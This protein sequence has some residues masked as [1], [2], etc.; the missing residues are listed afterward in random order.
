MPTTTTTTI[1]QEK[2][3]TTDGRVVRVTDWSVLTRTYEQWH[4]MSEADFGRLSF[5]GSGRR[6]VE[7]YC[8]ESGY[9]SFSDG[10]NTAIIDRIRNGYDLERLEGVESPNTLHAEQRKRRMTDDADGEYDH[11]AFLNGDAEYYVV[12]DR[13]APKRGLHVEIS[14]C[15]SGSVSGR[16]CSE[17]GVWTAQ[18]LRALKAARHDLSI[19]AT[20][21]TDHAYDGERSSDTHVTLKRYGQTMLAADWAVLFSPGGYRSLM[22]TCKALAAHTD[23]AALSSGLG[24]PQVARDWGLDW[25]RETR[26]LKI[27]NPRNA[28]SFPAQEMTRKL[29]EILPRL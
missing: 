19:V 12:K 3:T 16:V 26:T 10:D 6:V 1:P 20:N 8:R 22:F 2:Y 18:A 21:R 27:N 9:S 11:T 28:S 4:D 13:P 24:S 23:G 25:N 5:A 7:S 15:F 17:Y 14:L 29:G